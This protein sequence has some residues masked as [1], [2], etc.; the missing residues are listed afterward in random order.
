MEI[1]NLK[2]DMAEGN[3]KKKIKLSL[4]PNSIIYAIAKVLGYG[5]EKYK[6]ENSWK[7]GETTHYRDAMYRHFLSYI[8]NPTGLDES[9]F[10]HLYHVAANVAILIELEERDEKKNDEWRLRFNEGDK[11]GYKKKPEM[12]R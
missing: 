5:N 12:G 6:V 7:N 9:G 8:E 10:P 1:L 4:V 3:K 2:L 11:S